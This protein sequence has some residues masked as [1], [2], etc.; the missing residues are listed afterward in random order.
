MIWL[1]YAFVGVSHIGEN[2][3]YNVFDYLLE[4]PIL[5]LLGLNL[6]FI[7]NKKNEK[8]DV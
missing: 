1:D 4:P 7:Q 5:S 2:E 8:K 3:F 6:L